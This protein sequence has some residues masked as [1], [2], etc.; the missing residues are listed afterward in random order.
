M[1]A[2]ARD[3]S[4]SDGDGDFQETRP[5]SHAGSWYLGNAARLS[6]Q[7]EEFMSR[8]PNKLDGKDLPI[9]GARVIIAPH[10][11]YSYSG[12]CA[13]WA[14][15]IL[16]LAN[17]KR[18]F[19]LGPSHT[20]YLKGCAL[21]TFGKYSTPFGD[22]AVDG[23]AVDEL[24]KTQKFSPIPV[25]YDIQEHCLE[26]HLPYLWKRL[27][28]TLGSDS[29][30]F[31]PIVPVLVGDLSADGEKAIG[32]LLA[33]YL[34]DRKNAFIISSDF[35][36][37][38]KNYRYRPQLYKGLVRDQDAQWASLKIQPD[39]KN[40][41]DGSEPKD[42]EVPI[43]EV[44]KALDDLVM[45]SIKTGD[46][47]DYYSILKGTKNTVCGR[48]PIGVVLAALEEMGGDQSGESKGKFQF[49]QYQRSNL[50]EKQSDFSVSYVSA[51]A[52]L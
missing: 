33:P 31:P 40:K 29:S 38:G 42:A 22:L 11:G 47:N 34:A 25:E 8:V 7:L 52:V 51:Y 30:R 45:D 27:E 28:Q 1:A 48:H 3:W 41:A 46:H 21:S 49:V 43:H 12:P 15:K 10:A 37:W 5:A 19:L 35:C 50:V 26:M 4:Q 6:S 20:F 39:F 23:E 17:V 9:P 36:H 44:I 13:A 24:M 32:A 14:Y 18:V 16:D 2:S